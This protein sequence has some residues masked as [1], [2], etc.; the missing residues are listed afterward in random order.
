[1][2][3]K[4]LAPEIILVEPQL[5]ENIGTAARAMANFCLASL[6]LVNPRDGW[7]NEMA[8]KA[9]AGANE[10]IENAKL[11]D[12]IDAAVAD[13]NYVIAT[14]ARPRDMAKH[15]LTPER[16]IQEIHKRTKEEQKVGILFGRERVGLKNH[17]VALADAIVMAPVNPDFASLN[18]AQ[19]VLLIGY[20]WYKQQEN[21]TIGRETE[22]DGPGIL[23]MNYRA[24]RPVTK[25]E[26][27]GFFDHLEQEL[28]TSGFFKP[29]E[30][31]SIMVQNIRNMFQRMEATEQE[32]RTLRGIVS[33]LTRTHLRSKK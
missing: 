1:M 22:F 18:I 32:V 28:D 19:A 12:T 11:F 16:A 25:S 24:S 8:V 23:G 2:R 9:A 17:E 10:I 7:P 26:L 30:K 33:S 5:G 27:I 13:L 20:E 21:I 31:K 29:V 3:N 6:R 15:V 4:N 14:T